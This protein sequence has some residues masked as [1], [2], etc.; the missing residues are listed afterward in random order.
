MFLLV[1]IV[2]DKSLDVL[3]I[4]QELAKIETCFNQKITRYH[5]YCAFLQKKGKYRN[6]V[7]T[8]QWTVIE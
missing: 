6:T 1:F 3:N 8:S 2:F 7:L 4:T 5:I